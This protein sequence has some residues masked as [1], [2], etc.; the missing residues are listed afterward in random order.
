MTKHAV[1]IAGGG[2]TGLMLAGELALARVDVAIVERRASQDLVG[3]RA[4]GLHSRTLEVFDQRGIVDR[5]L[6]RGKVAQVAGFAGV[7]LDISDFPT[8]HNHGL[9]LRQNHIERILADWIGELH[10]PI[11]RGQ[12]ITGF[13]QDLTGVDV[14]LADGNSI[15]AQ[16]LVGCDGGRSVI[17]KAAGI[18]FPGSEP[19]TSNL[20]ADVELTQEP[21]QWGIRRDAIG[22]HALSKLEES[23]RVGVLVTEQRV[24]HTTE[25]TLRDLS[26]AM[27]VVFGTDYGIHNPASI[28]RFT[29]TARQAV[30]YRDGRIFLA[31]DAAHVHPPDGGQGLQTGV[32]DAVNLGWKLAQ[33]IDGTAPESL[34]DTYHTERR[35][36]AARALRNT[37]ASVALRREDDRTGAL[38]EIIAELFSMDQPRKRFAATLSGLDIHYDCGEGHPLLGRRMPDI[39]L[40][41]ASGSVRF[42]SLLHSARPV[43]LN[44]AEPG[45][46]DLDGWRDRVR[47]VDAKYVGEWELPVLGPVVEPSVVLVRPDGYVAWVGDR[48]RNGLAAALTRWFGPAG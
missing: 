4:G 21:P 45:S 27:V 43:L 26:E 18:A 14:A 25:P 1:V 28:S 37:M 35:P 11:Y 33:V 29:D 22:I 12:E 39:D 44:L 8:R 2:P 20:I 38:R 5:F 42:F 9:A 15:R 7:P 47:L 40:I 6:S 10:V 30:A 24:G 23:G 19:T 34:L 17:R 3:S 13:A 31:G 48:S 36:V 46:I 41:T 16:Y 32:Q